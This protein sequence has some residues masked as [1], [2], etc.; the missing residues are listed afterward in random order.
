MSD[1]HD[2]YVA[3]D[4]NT[5]DADDDDFDDGN[6][7][8]VADRAPLP[9]RRHLNSSRSRSL[10]TRTR[11]PWRS[12]NDRARSCFR[13]AWDPTTWVA[14]SDVEDAPPRPFVLSSVRLAHVT[15]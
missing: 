13:S 15:A 5:I 2:D 4:I 7:S 11:S 6:D 9:P 10:K 3:G 12:V 14:L 8:G 1:V